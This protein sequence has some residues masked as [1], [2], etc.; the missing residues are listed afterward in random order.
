MDARTI[1]HK[2]QRHPEEKQMQNKKHESSNTNY[3]INALLVDGVTK[4]RRLE[5][6]MLESIGVRTKSV[7]GAQ[8]AIQLLLTGVKFDFIFVDFDLSSGPQVP[9]ILFSCFYDFFLFC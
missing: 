4:T 6:N 1:G 2:R 5:H 3:I 8:E 9:K 7:I